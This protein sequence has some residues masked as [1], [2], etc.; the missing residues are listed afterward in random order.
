MLAKNPTFTSIA[1]LTLAL[2]IGANTAI[3]SLFDAVMLRSLPVR[4]PSQ[5]VVFRW[6]AH[7][8]PRAK[9]EVRLAIAR[10]ATLKILTAVR[11]RI[12]SSKRFGLRKMC[13]QV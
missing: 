13:F 9:R 2:G 5:L 12:P 6:T 3:F 1:L 8:A 7:K 10:G 4:D 11:C